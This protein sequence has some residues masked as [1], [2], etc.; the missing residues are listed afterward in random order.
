[1]K[2]KIIIRSALLLST[3]SAFA[4]DTDT[5]KFFKTNPDPAKGLPADQLY[6]RGQLFPFTFYSTGGGSEQKRGELLPE[7]ERIADQK[8]I[9]DAGV[10]MIGPQYELN[11]QIVADAKKYKVKAVYTIMP[12]IDGQRVDIKYLRKL[13]QEKK[14]IDV[15]KLRKSVADIVKREAV[16]PEIGWW[17]MTPEELRF[18]CK[19]DMLCLKTVSETIRENDPLKRPVYMYEPGHRD[20]K[21]LSKTVVFQNICGKGMYTNYSSKKNARVY[22]RWSAEQEVEAIKLSGNK[23]AIPIALPEMFQQPAE[24]ELPLI[25]TWVRHDVYSA[26]IGG[27]KGVMVFSASKRPNFAAREQYLKAYLQVCRELTGPMNLGRIFLFGE[28][29][30][31]IILSVFEGPENMEMKVGKD[32][33]LKL[34]N[35]ARTVPT[36]GMANIAFDNCRYVFI[37]NSSESEISAVVDG[38]VYGKGVTVEDI[39]KPEDK[40]TAPE[41]NFNIT[42]KPLEIKALKISCSK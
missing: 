24:N 32:N 34:D 14:N 29:R 31:D 21:A 17:D 1:M 20:I 16:N 33:E 42:L 8:Q 3:L 40:F 11:G 36:V 5:D 30:N 35:K 18:W 7:V 27:A 4:L 15:E 9:I 38:L 39:F 10:T 41:G 12:E 2:M 26:L 37:S 19:N 23:D 6:P 22:C 28:R 25:E 13:E